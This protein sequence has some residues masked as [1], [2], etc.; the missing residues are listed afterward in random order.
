MDRFTPDDYPHFAAQMMADGPL[1]SR[2]PDDRGM[3]E[4]R[5]YPWTQRQISGITSPDPLIGLPW[6]PLTRHSKGEAL[7]VQAGQRLQLRQPRLSGSDP[8]GGP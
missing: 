2:H 6:L 7:A 3:S 1:I 4:Y 8:R 5:Q